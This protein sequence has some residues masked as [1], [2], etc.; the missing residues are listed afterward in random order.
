MKLQKNPD[1]INSKSL[2]LTFASLLAI[3]VFQV[4]I[5]YRGVSSAGIILG[6]VLAVLLS[7]GGINAVYSR[8]SG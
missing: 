3:L 2:L 7:A 1:L 4:S 6:V 8:L 5:G